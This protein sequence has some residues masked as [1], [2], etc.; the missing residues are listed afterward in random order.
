MSDGRRKYSSNPRARRGN[1]LCA[2]FG[3]NGSPHHPRVSASLGQTGVRRNANRVADLDRRFEWHPLLPILRPVSRI[4]FYNGGGRLFTD[5]RTRIPAYFVRG[6]FYIRLVLSKSGGEPQ[7]HVHSNPGH[8][9]YRPLTPPAT[10]ARTT[11]AP[12]LPH[13]RRTASPHL[14]RTRRDTPPPRWPGSAARCWPVG[15][16]NSLTWVPVLATPQREDIH[17]KKSSWYNNRVGE[18]CFPSLGGADHDHDSFRPC[19]A[20]CG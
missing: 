16:S 5:N 17:T 19:S 20:A 10:P 3:A 13:S 6:S 2:K 4:D 11:S 18:P 1:P 15:T 8:L 14:R 12:P 9:R 7:L